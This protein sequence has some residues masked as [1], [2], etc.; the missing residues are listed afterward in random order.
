MPIDETDERILVAPGELRPDALFLLAQPLTPTDILVTAPG[1]VEPYPQFSEIVR[2]PGR[3]LSHERSNEHLAAVIEQFARATD[4]LPKTE[5]WERVIRA[6]IDALET[7]RARIRYFGRY[8]IHSRL[9]AFS[10][11]SVVPQ[12][13]LCVDLQDATHELRVE[14]SGAEH[15]RA[16]A[17][18]EELFAQGA[19]LSD[20]V[21]HS[22][23]NSWAGGWCTPRELYY[24]V[25]SQYFRNVIDPNDTEQ[26]D[27]PMLEQL[28]EFQRDA[29]KY[30]RDILSRF[31]G[32]F[33]A[34]V[35]GLGKTFIALALLSHLQRRN[36]EHAVVI[37]PPA[38]LPAWEELANEFRIELATVSLGK[39]E[40]LELYN[41]REI[42]VVDESHNFRNKGTLRVEAL[43]K[44]L[45]PDIGTASPRKAIL[46]SATPQNNNP[47]DL[48]NQIALFPDNYARLPYRGE[49]L[50]GFFHEVRAGR[51]SLVDLLQH[52]VVRRTRSY[53]QAQYPD[54][55]IRVR[56]GPGKYEQRRLEFPRR[57]SGEEQCLRYSIDRAY[58]GDY[59]SQLLAAIAGM[60]YPL[61]GLGLYV[62]EAKADD[63][64][65]AGLV[66]SGTS[67]RGLFRVLLLKRL[68]S[69]TH[70]LAKTLGRLLA[71]L[72][73]ACARIVAGEALDAPGQATAS[74]DADASLSGRERG[75][76]LT[77]FNLDRLQ[78]D[79][80]A[81]R[82]TV[83]Q[84]LAQ[85]ESLVQH[86]DEK[87]A[88]LE[89]YLTGRPP[90][91]H[92]TLVFTQFAETAEY[93]H[94]KLGQ[95]FGRID[96]ATGSS[97]GVLRKAQRFAPRANRRDIPQSE[98]I[99]L[100]I[101]TDVLSE[102]VNLQDADT[103]INYDLHWNPL[104]LIQRAGRIDRLGSK[105][106]EIHIASFLPQR[107]LED[108][109]GLETV[110]RRRIQEFIAVFGE[111]SVILPSSEQLDPEEMA[112]AYTGAALEN[113][114][115]TDEL[116]ALS[117]HMDELY[118]LRRNDPAEFS[119]IQSF[120][121]G[122]R[123]LGQLDTTI[124]AT[125]YD[126]Y[127]EF[128]TPQT[129]VGVKRVEVRAA[130]DSMAE[131]AKADDGKNAEREPGLG[132]EFIEQARREF[133]P[134][135]KAF[136]QQ[137]A[138]PR[139]S[140]HEMFV[141]SSLEVLRTDAVPTLVP[142]LNRMEAWVLSGHAQ[143]MLQ[144][145]ARVWKREKLTPQLVFDELRPLLA[146]FPM[147]GRE[148]TEPEL[149][150]ALLSQSDTGPSATS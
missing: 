20:D 21:A 35:V 9:L 62:V 13:P 59:F 40:D 88:R 78:E 119:R 150:G 69:S 60:R 33:L 19:D 47:T 4:R 129:G 92:R 41:D 131:A 130:F 134:L 16:R 54:A 138:K 95:R 106:E 6:W 48:E 10:H 39:L 82:A 125:K 26:D 91:Q 137:R 44:W 43:Q 94:E 29:Y 34:D 121:P 127:W 148:A 11:H 105:H 113:A 45:R 77:L 97:G 123:A 116:D 93:L 27:N 37:A 42:V 81:D 46:L 110:L 36:G 117:R 120:R 104:R 147:S 67:V 52:I 142:T 23:R 101:T 107:E 22:L 136:E 3:R 122:R 114:D 31:G 76:P 89:R 51:A 109:L 132:L 38:V 72:E 17:W 83:A 149:I 25:L 87:L 12:A 112:S 50:S 128:W 5:E 141:L 68:E 28:T 14:L 58:G 66:R 53:I 63:P 80:E 111:D 64:R 143:A 98:Q 146:R 99:D 18:F 61:Q 103:L 135:A 133:E 70:A 1:L 90:P 2:F 75:L 126:F 32:V 30:A 140:G 144:K 115:S 56:L 71:K 57:V 84:L 96:V 74:D 108:G 24:Y 85:L 7:E 124:A 73:S 118:R 65:L 100:L 102:G 79:L 55:T 15:A 49:G 8:P 86:P 145:Q 139:L